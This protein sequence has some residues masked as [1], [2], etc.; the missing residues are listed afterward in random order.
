MLRGTVLETVPLADAVL[1]L[2]PEPSSQGENREPLQSLCRLIDTSGGTWQGDLV[3]SR[4]LPAVLSPLFNGQP[5][6]E[7]EWEALPLRDSRPGYL[8]AKAVPHRWA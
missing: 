4:S 3:G 2:I 7:Q 5:R 6:S 8:Q 1:A